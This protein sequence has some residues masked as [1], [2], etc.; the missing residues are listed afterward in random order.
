MQIGAGRDG[1]GQIERETHFGAF[2]LKH[3]IYYQTLDMGRVGLCVG[4]PKPRFGAVHR[5]FDWRFVS[6]FGRVAAVWVQRPW[7]AL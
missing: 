7:V 2:F 6:C 1:I 3:N 4:S 5:V